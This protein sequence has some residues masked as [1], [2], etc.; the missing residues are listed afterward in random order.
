MKALMLVTCLAGLTVAAPEPSYTEADLYYMSHI[1]QAE[2]GYCEREMIEGVASV[3]MNRVNDD[4]FPDT[5]YGVVSQSGQYSTFSTVDLQVP[6]DD[7]IEVCIDVLEN[8]SKFPPDVIYQANVILGPVY[9]TLSTSYS[10]MYF[11]YG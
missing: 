2:A 11:C 7:V 9:K 5:V 4:R 3:I 10:T 6:T 1:V 8:G